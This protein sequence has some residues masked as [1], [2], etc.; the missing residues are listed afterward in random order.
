MKKVGIRTA[1]GAVFV[2]IMLSAIYFGIVTFAAWMLFVVCVTLWEFYRIARRLPV[3]PNPVL[4]FA[5]ALAVYGACCA[6]ALNVAGSAGSALYFMAAPFAVAIFIAEL[7]RRR[8]Q[9]FINI[10]YT[11]L[12]II[13]IV[14]PLSL[15]PV[16]YADAGRNFIFCYFILLW[17][18]DTF[19]YLVGIC[20]GK[21]RL[22]ARHSPKKS[23]EGY[24]GGICS[25]ALSSYILH[26]IF[27]DVQLLH[28]AATGLI[29][30]FVST[31]GD[32]TESMLK[33]NAG[34]KDAGRIMPG[35]GGL[36][37]RFDVTL[38][39]FP[40]VFMMIKIMAWFG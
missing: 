12:G 38:L 30:A 3:R 8:E 6:Q 20:I 16:L 25:V 34:I 1:S 7:Y 5:V 28:I 11:F 24:I 4:G 10:A 23:W 17:A 19:A 36:L 22:F 2:T 40:L 35:H 32:L 26:C 18:N 39:T 15:M 9:P 33:R 29:I 21:H 37:D 13:Y 14:L 31:L 27:P